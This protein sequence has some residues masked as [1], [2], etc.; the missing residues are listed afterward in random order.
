MD[1]KQY[2]GTAFY[3]NLFNAL[4]AR[5]Q[6]RQVGIAAAGVLGAVVVIV[7]GYLLYDQVTAVP[8][9]DV[10]VAQAK[11]IAGFMGHSRGLAR[12]PVAKRI[13]FMMD[14]AVSHN[15]PAKREELASALN[16]MTSKEKLECREALWDAGY[17]VLTKEVAAYYKTPAEEREEFVDRK[18]A[19]YFRAQNYLSGRSRAGGGGGG[20]GAGGGAKARPLFDDSWL[21]GM[22]T[23]SDGIVKLMVAKTKPRDRARMKPYIEAMSARLEELKEDPREKERLLARHG[24]MDS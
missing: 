12:L 23:D 10:K 24:N 7:G 18:L 19:D 22:P 14:L 17:S 13:K 2:M 20:G 5:Q 16:Q 6:G 11:D 1:L 4:F 8:A 9:P 21:E 3:R 15:E